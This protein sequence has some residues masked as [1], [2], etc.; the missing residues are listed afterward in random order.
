MIF[1]QVACGYI[2]V[3]VCKKLCSYLGL[4][5]PVYDVAKYVLPAGQ[6]ALIF[7]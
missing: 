5:P 4:Q 2:Q 6:L 3:L 1:S 7:M